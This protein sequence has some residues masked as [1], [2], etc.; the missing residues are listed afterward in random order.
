MALTYKESSLNH[1]KF[2]LSV[3]HFHNP[4]AISNNSRVL[5]NVF[6]RTIQF[7]AVSQIPVKPILSPCRSALLPETDNKFIQSL[8][9]EPSPVLEPILSSYQSIRCS[10]YSTDL[11]ID[12]E[13]LLVLTWMLTGIN[14]KPISVLVLELILNP[15]RS[16]HISHATLWYTHPTHI[17]P[18]TDIE[19]ILIRKL[20][21]YRSIL[22]LLLNLF[23][24]KNCTRE[25]LIQRT[26]HEPILLQKP[27]QYVSWTSN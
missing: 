11:G 24:F 13:C 2:S 5:A 23:Q 8:A 27:M 1:Q 9:P 7:P 26:N 18:G 25:C 15:Y 12:L 10:W 21:L 20:M 3:H 4:I 17:V 22:E 19:P 14:P 16:W 6:F